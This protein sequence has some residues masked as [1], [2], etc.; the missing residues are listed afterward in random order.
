MSSEP[1]F[2][3]CFQNFGREYHR[4]FNIHVALRYILK[5]GHLQTSATKVLIRL[6]PSPSMTS[7]SP[8]WVVPFRPKEIV[9]PSRWVKVLSNPS[10]A[11]RNEPSVDDPARLTSATLSVTRPKIPPSFLDHTPVRSAFLLRT[12]TITSPA[13]QSTF[14]SASPWNT[15]SKPSGAP[16]GIC[17]ASVCCVSIVFPPL[18]R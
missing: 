3:G 17:T 5:F 8:G 11:C 2:A 9:R 18:H 10:R 15:S 1:T 4:V 12:R 7:T 13:S 6:T 14:S 16:A